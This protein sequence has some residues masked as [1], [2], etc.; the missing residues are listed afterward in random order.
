MCIFKFS[1]F[2]RYINCTFFSPATGRVLVTFEET[3]RMSSFLLALAIFNFASLTSNNYTY[4]TW[5]VPS[6]IMEAELSHQM[7]PRIVHAME[8]LTASKFPLPKMD[9][10]ALA[11]LEPVAMENWGMNTYRYFILVSQLFVYLIAML[12]DIY[13]YIYM[14]NLF[15]VIFCI[16]LVLCVT[17]KI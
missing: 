8:E 12:N 13:I 6:K 2:I 10:V 4:S 11:D 14:C 9:Q 17:N 15:V 7:T 5:A 3:P 1:I 16:I